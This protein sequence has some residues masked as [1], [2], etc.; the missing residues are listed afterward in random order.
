MSWRSRNSWRHTT[1]EDRKVNFIRSFSHGKCV[2]ADLLWSGTLGKGKELSGDSNRVDVNGYNRGG[3]IPLHISAAK[4]NRNM[5]KLLLDNGTIVDLPDTQGETSLLLAA[6]HGHEGVVRLL[7]DYKGLRR[8]WI[9]FF[10]FFFFFSSS[11]SS[12]LDCACSKYQ[13]PGSGRV[14]GTA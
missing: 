2:S 14:D 13:L 9:I 12:D 10:F 6:Y 1:R 3:K 11:F 5:A 4:G 7:L 8:F